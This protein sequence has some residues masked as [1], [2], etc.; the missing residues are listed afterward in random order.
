MDLRR[1]LRQLVVAEIALAAVF[2]TVELIAE[3]FLPGPLR[4][5]MAE[6]WD[7]SGPFELV[8][9]AALVPLLV[10]LVVSWIGLWRLW[11][12]ARRIYLLVLIAGVLLEAAMG[13]TVT[14]GPGAALSALQSA[15]SGFIVALIYVTPLSAAFE[16]PQAAPPRGGFEVNMTELGPGARG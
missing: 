10:A 13:P 14:S 15:V 1:L 12:P 11:R 16:R 5:W 4:Q 7:D 8:I 2:V 9:L 6:Q 3:R